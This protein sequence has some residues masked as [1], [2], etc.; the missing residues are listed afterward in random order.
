MV[1]DSLM[2]NTAFLLKKYVEVQRTEGRSHLHLLPCDSGWALSFP[3]L[4]LHVKSNT[5]TTRLVGTEYIQVYQKQQRLLPWGPSWPFFLQISILSHQGWSDRSLLEW[6][7]FCTLNHNWSPQ[8][9]LKG[10]HWAKINELLAV[11]NIW[12]KIHIFIH[13]YIIYVCVWYNRKCIFHSFPHIESYSILT[14]GMKGINKN[15][16]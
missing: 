6:C 2:Q 3:N 14:W 8:I 5:D 16:D 11:I 13:S 7:L 1:K 9:I 12:L 15:S 4:S 10:C